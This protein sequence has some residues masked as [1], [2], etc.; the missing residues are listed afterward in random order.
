MPTVLIT[1][2]TG[3]VGSACLRRRPDGA[4]VHA[5]ARRPGLAPA[6]CCFHSL[7]LFDAAAVGELL[8]TLRPTHLL[9]LAWITTPGHYWTSPENQRWVA[10]SLHLLRCFAESGGRRAVLAGTCSEYDWSVGGVCHETRTPLRPATVYG[11]CKDE[12]RRRAE[13][14]A[15]ASGVSFAWG[16]LFFLYGPGEHPARLIPSVALALLAGRPA[17]CTAGTHCRDFLHVDDAADALWRLLLGDAEGPF[18]VGSGEAPSVRSVVEFVAEAAGRPDL[19]RLGERPTPAGEPPLLVADVG[20]LRDELGW[21]PQIALE[22]GI[23]EA[24]AG[25]EARPAL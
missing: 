3:F 22:R 23:A 10:A 9:H 11:R 20:R 8:S 13:E 7:D 19:L 15:R 14:F 25:W 5:A 2:A 12:L 18:N 24:V 4:E 17:A 21:R 1:G 6:D 16:R